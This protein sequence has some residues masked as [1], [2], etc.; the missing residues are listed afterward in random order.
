MKK[1]TGTVST[2]TASPASAPS[3]VKRKA[4]DIQAEI[5]RL[6]DERNQ[7]LQTELEPM[8]EDIKT[9]LNEL[10]ALVS[11]VLEV[12][13][14]YVPPF[15]VNRLERT[16][17]NLVALL[18]TPMKRTDLIRKFSG[19]SK[20]VGEWLDGVVK[21]KVVTLTKGTTDR[22]IETMTYSVPAN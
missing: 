19:S 21:N 1:P 3:E 15:T 20:V 2:S 7:A 4:S 14:N 5:N 18:S 11:S 17:E 10:L 12:D 16:T 22:G 9:K 13:G 6:L 8:K